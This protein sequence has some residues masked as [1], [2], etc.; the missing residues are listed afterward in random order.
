MRR[1]LV[2]ASAAVLVLAVGYAWLSIAKPFDAV[3]RP[4]A[5]AGSKVLISMEAEK[6]LRIDELFPDGKAFAIVKGARGFAIEG[7]PGLELSS[8]RILAALYAVASLEAID[9]IDADPQRPADFGLDQPGLVT[10]SLENASSQALEIGSRSPGG[11]Y[12]V[13]LPGSTTVYT[14][15]GL[16]IEN[17]YVRPDN[18]RERKLPA[19]DVQKISLLRIL[20][21]DLHLE[22][23]DLPDRYDPSYQTSMLV[24]KPYRH[25]YPAGPDSLKAYLKTLPPAFTIQDFVDEPGAL[26]SL[27][28]EPPV[29]DLELGDGRSSLKLLIGK[30]AS[31]TTFY[32]RLSGKPGV[33]TLLKTD[34]AFVFKADAFQLIN[35]LPLLIPIEKVSALE[36]R[37][38][39]LSL[40]FKLERRELPP[41]GDAK[42]GEAQG[43]VT[44]YRLGNRT[45]AE[46]TFR[47]IYQWIVGIAIEGPNPKAIDAL[48][49]PKEATVVFHLNAGLPPRSFGF[50]PVSDDFYALAYDGDAEFLVT[51][52][53]MERLS[54][55]ISEALGAGP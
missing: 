36:F 28:L 42:P 39:D 31:P 19:V 5:G 14:A 13:R 10:I 32:A 45:I 50:V 41:A 23:A 16:A 37:Y 15:P 1:G 27:G 48:R 6:V 49:L 35:H 9:T 20:R 2:A 22:I 17:F 38:K 34:L 11:D 26:A 53:Q 46:A 55:R 47:N 21:A 8:N 18:F 40:D 25:A 43:F 24:L 12:Y 51:K 54:R 7:R 30:E 52:S 44:T 33:F 3:P 29:L 4:R